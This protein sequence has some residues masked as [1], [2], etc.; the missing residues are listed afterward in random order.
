MPLIAHPLLI[1]AAYGRGDAPSLVSDLATVLHMDGLGGASIAFVL[2]VFVLGY[3]LIQPW[4]SWKYQQWYAVHLAMYAA[5]ALAFWHQVAI[6]GSLRASVVFAVYWWLV[7]CLTVAAVVV[8][9]VWLPLARSFRH[10]FAVAA[11]VPETRNVTSVLIEGRDLEAYRFRSGQ[12]V[13][14]RFLC[15]RLRWESHPYSLSLPYD[16]KRLRLSVKAVGDFSGAVPNVPPGT[17]VILE[18]PYGIFTSA[19]TRAPKVLCLAFGIGITPIRAIAEDLVKQGRD[20][21]LVYGSLKT[22]EIALRNEVEQLSAR[23]GMPVHHVLSEECHPPLPR[24]GLLPRVTVS[25][26]FVTRE[27]LERVVPDVAER[28]VFLCGPPIVMWMLRKDLAALGVP[29]ARVFSERFSLH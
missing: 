11:V 27:Y 24:L 19:R 16:G 4:T 9:R 21:V 26:G 3:S 28:D 2:L 5:I 1:M 14:V 18:G 12:F 15:P 13:M 6:G 8:Y 20:V 7:W 22:D 17:R 25:G 10:R 23:Y 29:P